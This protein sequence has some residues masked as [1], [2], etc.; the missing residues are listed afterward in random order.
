[1]PPSR[2]VPAA[3]RRAAGRLLVPLA[4]A[5]PLA[6]ALAA[7]GAPQGAPGGT[8]A[9]ADGSR[10]GACESRDE[11]GWGDDGRGHACERRTLTLSR[12]AA[13]RLEA[14]PN[15]GAT[16]RGSDAV[17][18]PH[19]VA[20][21]KAGA[22]TDAEAER[23]AAGVELVDD[24]GTLRA[25]GPHWR[26]REGDRRD[27][28]WWSVE[29]RVEVPRRTDLDVRTN[30]GGAHVAGVVGRLRLETNNGGV[31]VDSV[32]GAVTAR[33][34]NGGVHVTLA[35][36]EW[37]GGGLAG[38]GLEAHSNN[39]GAELRVPEGYA[40]RVSVGTNNGPLAVEFPVTVQGRLDPRRIEIALGGGGAP[41]RVTTNNGAARLGRVE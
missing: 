30:N 34:N 6:A 3:A 15:G 27:R 39:G 16:V 12:R 13:L 18:A 31:T 26:D 14:G 41:V 38:A 28:F 37:E 24:G 8:V 9:Q 40:A 1:M 19:V 11:R 33:S 5:A 36:R 25:R 22:R 32:G 17:R 10:A 2:S 4:A 35:G 20:V 29:W 21:V 7:Q 23:I